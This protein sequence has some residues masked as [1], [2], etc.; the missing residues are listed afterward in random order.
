MATFS[1]EDTV[2]T[3]TYHQALV[4]YWSCKGLSYENIA[5]RY[6]YKKSWVVWQMSFVYFKLGLNRKDASGRSLHWNERRRVI[7]EKICPIIT[8]LTN[9][10][11]DLLERFP[12]IPPNV[13][14]G[15]IVDLRP[16]IPVPPSG[17]LIPLPEPLPE[18]PP[19]PPDDQ[20][21]PPEPPPDFY[22]IELYNAWL[23]VVEDGKHPDPPPPPPPIIVR[24]PERRGVMWG[25]LLGLG[26]VALLGCVAV[27]V[28]AYFLGRNNAF[29]PATETSIPTIETLLPTPQPS[30]SI[31]PSATIQL[32]ETQAPSPTETPL[33]TDTL[34]PSAV[35]T[36]PALFFDD[37]TNGKSE[38]WKVEYGT[39]LIVNET[40]TF[41]AATLMTLNDS[42]TDIEVP[43][44][45]II[46][47]QASAII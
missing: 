42:W 23:A 21:P 29:I 6:G 9:D 41:D 22:P 31:E 27:G 12:L 26:F 39:P 32:T 35:P 45:S 16:E 20:V 28:L 36:A 38:K 18:P 30:A 15:S 7:R 8:R 1:L 17:P 2:K 46:V 5:A 4:V 14:E 13:L 24:P 34:T 11:P 25:R 43:S 3:F 10:D 37:F 47:R 44:V 19:L 40:L 33:P